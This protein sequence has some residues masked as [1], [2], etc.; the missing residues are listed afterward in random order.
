[1]VVFCVVKE[2]DA[3]DEMRQLLGLKSWEGSAGGGSAGGS[4]LRYSASS[5]PRRAVGASPRSG[6]GTPGR[7]GMSGRLAWPEG[8]PRTS[9]R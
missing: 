4:A 9:G 5:S 6:G 8:D 2:R 1:M 3:A 7:S